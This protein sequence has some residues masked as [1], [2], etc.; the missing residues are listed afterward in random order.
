M[1]TEQDLQVFFDGLEAG[2]NSYRH[3]QALY[4]EQVAFGFNYTNLFEPNENR[5]S[6]VLAFIL[7]PNKPHGQKT[8]FL[9]LFVELFELKVPPSLFED[10]KQIAVHTPYTTTKRRSIDLTI[11][12]GNNNYVIGI[13][14]KI[15][16]AKDQ[17]NQLQ[18]YAAELEE[19]TRPYNNWV[20][21]YLTRRD[22]GVPWEGSI[23]P[24][25]RDELG[26]KFKSKS[27]K[28]IRNFLE[29]CELVCKA[30]NVRAF[31]KDFKQYINRYV[32]QEAI[33]SEQQLINDYVR[34]HPSIIGN[35]RHLMLHST[36]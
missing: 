21:F 24:K 5:T 2:L 13:E 33:M 25:R 1:S 10:E 9:K 27:W 20:L 32:L 30:D 14:N 15:W 26:E 22:G 16:E 18:D 4:D 8:T 19:I 3:V 6:K 28:D 12:F 36:H 31:L 11:H 35:L 23:T 34:N 17:K 7:D 29:Q